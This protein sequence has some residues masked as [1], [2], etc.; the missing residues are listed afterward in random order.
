MKI[1]VTAGS[2]GDEAL[3]IPEHG[4]MYWKPWWRAHL[5]AIRL[6]LQGHELEY[7]E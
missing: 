4:A 6:M 3:F 7:V 2:S 5:H 1:R